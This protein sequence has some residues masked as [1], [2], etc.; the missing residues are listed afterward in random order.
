MVC[1]FQEEPCYIIL[2]Y[3]YLKNENINL[4]ILDS[5]KMETNSF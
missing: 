3:S 1:S 5:T 4:C 2:Q